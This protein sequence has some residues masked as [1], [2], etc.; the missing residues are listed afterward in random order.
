MLTPDR[1]VI[2]S[3]LRFCQDLVVHATTHQKIVDI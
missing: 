1:R 3:V 2:R